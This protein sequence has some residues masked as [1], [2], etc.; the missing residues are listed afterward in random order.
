[1][2]GFRILLR[3]APFV[4]GLVAV[5]A[6]L[7]RRAAGRRSLPSAE[8]RAI[9]PAPA[10]DAPKAAPTYRFEREPIDI[11]AVVDDLLLGGR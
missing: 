10:P 8:V 4:V 9:G 7:T 6:W 2:P 5:R 1:M 3:A 11:V